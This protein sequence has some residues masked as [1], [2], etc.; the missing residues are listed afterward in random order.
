ML[1][2]DKT[3]LVML[4]GQFRATRIVFKSLEPDSIFA[5][6]HFCSSIILY[7]KLMHLATPGGKYA[8]DLR[9]I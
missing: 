9:S 2:H 3:L 1:H 7:V 6:G 4:L 5:M 8:E